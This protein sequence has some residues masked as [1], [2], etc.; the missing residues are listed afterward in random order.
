MPF[1]VR[2]LVTADSP[3]VKV[4]ISGDNVV[5]DHRW[6]LIWQMPKAA[7]AWSDT[8]FG[9]VARPLPDA[10]PPIDVPKGQERAEPTFPIAN[11]ASLEQA[12]GGIALITGGLAEGE[13]LPR[14]GG[15]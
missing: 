7:R 13:V 8:P 6:R 14:M 1:T 9:A 12:E 5:Q 4:T 2:L 11:W 10:L 15:T 3:L